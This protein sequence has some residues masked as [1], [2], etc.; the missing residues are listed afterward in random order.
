MYKA[1]PQS[2]Y[3][4]KNLYCQENKDS[5]FFVMVRTF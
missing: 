1:T 3:E 4:K 2:N 5:K